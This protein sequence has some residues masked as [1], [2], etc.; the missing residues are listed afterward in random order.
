M[1][2]LNTARSEL[3]FF[4]SPESV[5]GGY[6]ILSHT[7]T[8]DELLFQDLV[9]LIAGHAQLGENPRDF[10]PEKIRKCCLLAE[11]HG[12]EWAWID[13]CCIDKTSSTDLSEAINS[14]FRYYACAEVCYAHLSDVLPVDAAT[15]EAP[16]SSFRS[17]RWH[18][19]CWTLQELIAPASVV[20]LASD[21]SILGDKLALAPLLHSITGIHPSVLTRESH[22]AVMSVAE[23]MSWAANRRATR[24]E[25]EAYCLMGLFNVHMP[26]IYGEGHQAFERLQHEIMKQAFDTTIFAWGR[27]E[28]FRAP[29][30]PMTTD[31]IYWFFNTTSQNHVYLLANSP[32]SFKP[33]HD[34]MQFRFTPS[35]SHALQPYLDWQWKPSHVSTEGLRKLGFV[36]SRIQYRTSLRTASAAPRVHS[37]S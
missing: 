36:I 18:K 2:L 11:E 1:W 26:T 19:R 34:H 24:V 35:T 20:F 37:G 27:W 14:M 6:A 4:S 9:T 29:L 17:A 33:F 30:E 10:V 8:D 12:Y 25:D 15:L 16:D 22:F 5:T 7:W 28:G 3:H 32:Q 21:W 13:T 31:E 23:R